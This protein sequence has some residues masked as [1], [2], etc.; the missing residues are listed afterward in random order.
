MILMTDC[1]QCG[2]CCKTLVI[3]AN[4]DDLKEYVEVAYPNGSNEEDTLKDDFLFVYKCLTEIPYTDALN[5]NPY[6]A[7][8][9]LHEDSHIYTCPYLD[10]NNKCKIHDKLREGAMCDGYPFYKET[11]ELTKNWYTENCGY[12]LKLKDMEV[13]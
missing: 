7:T 11:P 4:T 2:M 8:W 6:L 5:I 9:S 12:R 3:N 10:S 1:L 13:K